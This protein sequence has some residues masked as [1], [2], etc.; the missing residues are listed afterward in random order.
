MQSQTRGWCV[1]L[2]AVLLL[3]GPAWADDNGTDGGLDRKVLDGQ[4]HRTLRDVINRG[5]EA[6]NAGD[7]AACYGMF[8]GALMTARP[9][10]D[11]HPDQQKSISTALAEAERNPDPRRRA[12]VLRRALDELRT[13]LKEGAAAAAPA[14]RTRPGKVETKKDDMPKDDDKRPTETEKKPKDDEDVKKPKDDDEKKPKDDDEKKPK[15]ED[16]K[17]KDDEDKKP[18]DEADKK[19]KDDEKKDAEK[20]DE[21]K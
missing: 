4:L 19:P 7:P 14:P 6:Y 9:L 10:I 2:A 20:K 15:D 18:K 12:W 21:E 5:A 11:H 3:V 13:E 8:R 16:K 17:P 1:A